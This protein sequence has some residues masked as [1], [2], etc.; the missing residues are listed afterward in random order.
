MKLRKMAFAFCD[1]TVSH[2]INTT[3]KDTFKQ[4]KVL[5]TK[6][7]GPLVKQEETSLMMYVVC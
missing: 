2:F 3:M 7:H 1:T 5:L 4:I 6:L